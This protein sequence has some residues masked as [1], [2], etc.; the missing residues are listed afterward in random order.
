MTEKT[1]FKPQKFAPIPHASLE[2]A[3]IT[4]ENIDELAKWCRGTVY[5]IRSYSVN[6]AGNLQLNFRNGYDNELTNANVGDL[7]Y[8]ID[9][10]FFVMKK[11]RF[12]ALYEEVK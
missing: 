8:K 12:D 3:L 5:E 9:R 4:P 10:D 6:R 7:L 1:E 2:G 11:E